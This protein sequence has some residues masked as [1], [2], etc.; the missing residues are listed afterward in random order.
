MVSTANSVTILSAFGSSV[1]IVKYGTLRGTAD[2]ASTPPVLG[3][4]K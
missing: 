2:V 1:S 4:Q 3:E